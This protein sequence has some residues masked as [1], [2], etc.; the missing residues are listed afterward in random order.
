MR[1][2]TALPALGGL[3]VCLAASLFAA[4]SGPPVNESLDLTLVTLNRLSLEPVKER[5]AGLLPL[6]SKDLPVSVRIYLK[7]TGQL[8][9]LSAA[10][11]RAAAR[12]RRALAPG[13]RQ[14]D[15]L[16]DSRRVVQAVGLWLDT[17]VTPAPGV[18]TDAG[19]A[20]PSCQDIRQEY[21]RVSAMLKD[22]QADAD[23]RVLVAVALL[24]ALKVPARVA[25]ARGGLVAQYWVAA[26][27]P[28]WTPSRRRGHNHKA[29]R[30]GA[31][32]P[33]LGWWECM[34]PGVGDAEI[35]AWSL[36]ASSLARLRWEPKQ[37]LQVSVLGWERAAFGEGDSRAAHA[38]FDASLACGRLTDTAQAQSLSAAAG[39]VLEG[40]TQ[41]ASVLWVLTAEHWR[42]RTEGVMT[43]MKSVQILGPYRPDLPS[44]GREQRGAA[45]ASDL[46]A[47]GVWSDRPQRLRLHT[48]PELQNDWASPPPALGML[49]WYDLGVRRPESVLEAERK[50]GSVDGVALRAD[51]LSPRQGWK[52]SVS[53]DGTTESAGTEVGEDGHFALP[54]DSALDTADGLDVTLTGPDGEE[55]LQRLPQWTP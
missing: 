13:S 17:H 43:A 32:R 52:I 12:I 39:A 42:M 8:D 3:L 46:E 35:D 40:L 44:W 9:T 29:A 16:R 18:D 10:V 15:A 11:N 30:S 25:T 28:A 26:Q 6:K 23:G 19:Q 4:G 51:N 36:D 24:R 38:A 2:P 1:G 47:E 27:A 37:E 53:A 33:P 20:A 21:P 54:L 49:H 7:P 45:R 34:E 14:K 22:G 55:D 5:A 50:P 41:G 31:P 48:D